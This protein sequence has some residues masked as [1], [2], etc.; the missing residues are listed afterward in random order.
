MDKIKIAKLSETAIIP[1]RKHPDDAGLDLYSNEEKEISS[2]NFGIISTG[3]TIDLH[4]K[5][6]GLILPK[7][8]NDFLLGGGVVDAGYQGEILV[9]IINPYK[10]PLIIH[11]GQAIAQILIVPIETP[12]VMEINKDYIHLRK[13]ARGKTGGLVDENKLQK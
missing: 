13:S 9:K 5:Y 12:E 1:N 2:F 8:R 4:K 11:K 6:V 10:I 3:I 7:S